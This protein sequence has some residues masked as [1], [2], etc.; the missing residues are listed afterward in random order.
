VTFGIAGS[1]L[2]RCIYT[3]VPRDVFHQCGLNGMPTEI[4]LMLGLY[5]H[6]GNCSMTDELFD[7]QRGMSG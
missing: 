5:D 2:M 7:D 4:A 6:A 1:S 3:C